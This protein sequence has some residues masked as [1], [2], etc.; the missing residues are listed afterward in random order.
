[1]IKKLGKWYN[2]IMIGTKLCHKCG[3][4]KPLTDFYVQKSRKDGRQTECKECQNNRH[5]KYY[6]DNTQDIK[7]K[8]AK[9]YLDHLNECRQKSQEYSQSEHGKMKKKQYYMEHKEQIKIW[10][11]DYRERNRE[12]IREKARL[13][14]AKNKGAYRQYQ[15]EWRAEHK[16]QIKL[17]GLRYRQ[18]N[19]EKLNKSHVERLHNDPLFNMKERTR[20]M[21][22]YA[23]RVNKHN[24]T[25]HTAEI[26]GCDLD[27]LCTHLL[28]TWEKNYNK[29]W[30]GEPYHIDHIVPLATA[31][32]KEDIINLC[33]YTN[34]QMLT[35]EDNMAKSD[36]LI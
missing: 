33:H 13:R 19:K 15:K 28:A 25:S 1:M 36:N 29:P 30:S 3:E 26:V 32:T 14:Y 11:N 7:R 31:K 2:Y 27:K 8:H 12:K 22:R 21:I 16:E 18:E 17:S 23:L 24:K 20:N 10:R 4:I 6:K 9:Y 35:P 5:K 34:L